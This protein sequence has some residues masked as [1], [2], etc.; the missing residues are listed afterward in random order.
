MKRDSGAQLIAVSLAGSAEQRLS[1]ISGSGE[2]LA[3][4]WGVEGV[5]GFENPIWETALE[6]LNAKSDWSDG[7]DE[8]PS[9]GMLDST[10]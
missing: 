8:P 6:T 1:V 10:G 7:E 2:E 4:G 9:L 5:E 3:W